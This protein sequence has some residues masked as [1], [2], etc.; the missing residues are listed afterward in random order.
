MKVQH[1]PRRA[2][3][4]AHFTVLPHTDPHKSAIEAIS[5][6]HSPD[7]VVQNAEQRISYGNNDDSGIDYH[8]NLDGSPVP[9][10]Y[11]AA[12]AACEEDHSHLVSEIDYLELLQQYLMLVVR[13]DLAVRIER[14][15]ESSSQTR[16][17]NWPTEDEL[18]VLADYFEER[19]DDRAR[20]AR[21][22][23]HPVELNSL[24]HLLTEADQHEA[25]CVFAERGLRREQEKRRKPDKRS[26][27]AVEAKRRWLRG[28]ITDAELLAAGSAA[29]LVRIKRS[30]E[31]KFEAA[32][33]AA[34]AATWTAQA[35][36]H[37][38][39]FMVAQRV[40]SEAG[41][42]FAHTLE[43]DA[44]TAFELT[45]KEWQ[46]DWIMK[47]AWGGQRPGAED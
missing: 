42:A 47:R 40:Q 1:S 33:D 45:E 28:E 10:G 25:A 19:G 18:L 3:L 17:S 8:D 21:R 29:Q 37:N 15:K 6:S 9:T 41:L 4:Y 16:T 22:V 39:A 38:V 32:V 5:N 14:L 20:T 27:A 12:N 24:L 34:L 36:S 2:N 11:V 43:N 31:W 44:R 30:P 46:V 13:P 35:D 26:W 23:W 7:W